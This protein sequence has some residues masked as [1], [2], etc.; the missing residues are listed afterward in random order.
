M[1]AILS[2]FLIL[3]YQLLEREVRVKAVLSWASAKLAADQ[4]ILDV[5]V[6]KEAIFPCLQFSLRHITLVFGPDK[7]CKPTNS[8][9]H[10]QS[11]STL[12]PD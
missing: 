5:V 2:I 8:E 6:L 7:T 10:K 1:D 9:A 11:A 12:L 3:Y 4:V